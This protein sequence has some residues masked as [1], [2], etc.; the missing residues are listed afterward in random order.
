M[1]RIRGPVL[2]ALLRSADPEERAVAEEEIAHA[3]RAE[4]SIPRA[5]AVLRVARS[6]LYRL[7][8]PAAR[9]AAPLRGPGRPRRTPAT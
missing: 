8:S 2:L 5:A 3:L 9:S 6:T 4:G 7:T 1:S